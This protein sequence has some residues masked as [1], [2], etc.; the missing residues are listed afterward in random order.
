MKLKRLSV[1]AAAVTAPLLLTA[2][3]SSFSTVEIDP[4]EAADQSEVLS[5]DTTS[6]ERSTGPD[7]SAEDETPIAFVVDGTV[8]DGKPISLS[9]GQEIA[10]SGQE[11][12][13]ATPEGIVSISGNR[14]KAQAP[15]ATSI[16]GQ[17]WNRQVVV[18]PLAD[19]AQGE[20]RVETRTLTLTLSDDP[21]VSGLSITGGT[22]AMSVDQIAVFPEEAQPLTAEVQRS[23]DGSS[24]SVKTIDQDGSQ[25]GLIAVRSGTNTVIIVDS[26]GT[27]R[28][29]AV[30]VVENS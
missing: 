18:Y 28:V 27:E 24:N 14:V 25:V 5:E 21:A 2:C 20:S 8:F 12:L 4:S 10:V 7:V 30:T 22:L 6:D 13:T 11:E 19:P 3:G 17:D 9:V 1:T 26:Q 29:L 15:G 16:S 23:L